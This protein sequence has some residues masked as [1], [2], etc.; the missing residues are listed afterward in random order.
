MHLHATLTKSS[1]VTSSTTSD[2]PSVDAVALRAAVGAA[3]CELSAL[4]VPPVA[5]VTSYSASMAVS[6][7]VEKDAAASAIKSLFLRPR[8]VL[9]PI[10]ASSSAH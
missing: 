8:R 1:C 9:L 5:A 7:S 10:A 2:A 4:A 6:A 3:R